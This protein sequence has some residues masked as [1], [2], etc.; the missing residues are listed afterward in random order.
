V[1]AG[2]QLTA[3]Q[4]DL[5]TAVDPGGNK[6]VSNHK[7]LVGTQSP[8]PTGIVVDAVEGMAGATSSQTTFDGIMPDPGQVV[9][10]I[11]TVPVCNITNKVMIAFF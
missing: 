11:M 5:G 8:G 6:F 3:G 2:F 9:G 4:L 10:P 7:S 1:Q